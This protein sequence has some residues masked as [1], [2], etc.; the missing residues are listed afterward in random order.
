[1]QV[2]LSWPNMHIRSTIRQS[3]SKVPL[4]DCR[5]ARNGW[6]GRDYSART[7]A[8]CSGKLA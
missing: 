7:G 1:M 8:P 2:C 6:D 3:E 5:E 4:G